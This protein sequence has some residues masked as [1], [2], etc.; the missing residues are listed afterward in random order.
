MSSVRSGRNSTATPQELRVQMESCREAALSCLLPELLT[1][2]GDFHNHLLGND[3]MATWRRYQIHTCR[4]WRVSN[5]EQICPVSKRQSTKALGGT[6][7]KSPSI[8]TLNT[9]HSG[10]LTPVQVVEEAGWGRERSGR[11]DEK[12][13]TPAKN[14]TPAG[15]PKASLFTELSN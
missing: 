14:R 1:S 7:G 3:L 13:L 6:G 4:F 9:S 10:P 5:I 12:Q 2:G 8:P 15:Q 11:G